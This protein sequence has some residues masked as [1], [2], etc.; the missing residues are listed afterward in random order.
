MHT[1]HITTEMESMATFY[2]NMDIK[3]KAAEACPVGSI[4]KKRV[5]FAV[6]VGQRKFD[7][8]SIGSDIEAH[9]TSGK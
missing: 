6:P 8:Q 9:R 7:H 2:T 1:S 3:D 5:G 4:L